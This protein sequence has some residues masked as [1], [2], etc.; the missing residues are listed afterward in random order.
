MPFVS[1]VPTDVSL[2]CKPAPGLLQLYHQPSLAAYRSLM[3]NRALLRYSAASLDLVPKCE[4]TRGM[5][6]EVSILSRCGIR[7]LRSRE[8]MRHGRHEDMLNDSVER[9]GFLTRCSL[10]VVGCVLFL[11]NQSATFSGNPSVSFKLHVGCWPSRFSRASIQQAR[12]S[13]WMLMFCQYFISSNK[14]EV[15]VAD[16]SHQVVQE[17]SKGKESNDDDEQNTRKSEFHLVFW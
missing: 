15:D 13:S 16:K 8:L 9:A 5:A 11:I 10:S 2:T 3:E 14:L 4:G 1:S 12:P 6:R 17:R 7:S